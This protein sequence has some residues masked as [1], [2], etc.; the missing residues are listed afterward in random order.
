MVAHRREVSGLVGDSALHPLPATSS[1]LPA[2]SSV[3]ST[4]SP[5]RSS[6]PQATSFGTVGQILDD[7]TETVDGLDTGDLLKGDL[8]D[9]DVNVDLDAD[10][11]APIKGAVA[12]NASMAATID[13]SVAA[14]I[15]SDDSAA[16][17]IAR[18][19]RC[20]RNRRALP[21]TL[22]DDRAMAAAAIIG[23]SSH[24]NAG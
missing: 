14:N 11:A 12:A 9:V 23:D 10:L 24:P 21:M 3:R 4:R 1:T 8:L 2:T 7:V 13:A 20:A 16:T 5:D 6:T 22:T 15:L 17:A 19:R 18:Y